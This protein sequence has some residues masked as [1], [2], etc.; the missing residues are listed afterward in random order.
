M[1]TR[2]YSVLIFFLGLSAAT[3]L[4]QSIIRFQIGSGIFFLDS[5]LWWFV[6]VNLTGFT[7]SVLTLKYYQYQKYSFALVAG[8][9]FTIIDNCHAIIIFARLEY[10]KLSSYNIPFLLLSST[11]GI[12][13]AVSLIFLGLKRKYW[14]A[15]TGIFMFAVGLLYLITS[16]RMIYFP[17]GILNTTIEKIGQWTAFASSFIPV[18]FILHFLG[19]RKKLRGSDTE[20]PMPKQMIG[21][22]GLGIVCFILTV[23]YG[24]W[25]FFESRSK[26][27]WEQYNFN[28]TKQ[29][30]K[31]FEFRTF[32][33]S[34]G[35]TLMYEL[36]R[37][38][39]Y[40][41]TKKYPLIVSLPYGAQTGTDTIKQIEGAVAAEL[42][43]TE[44][45]REKYPSFIFI[46][47]CPPGSGWGGIPNYPS[48][49]SLVYETI[50]SLDENFSIDTKRRYVIGLSRGGYGAW[51]FICTRPDMFA[52]AIPVAGGGNPTL[53][54][55]AVD[56]AVW[57]FHGKED[58][59]VPVEA[60]RDMIH[61]LQKAGGH[62][63]YTEFPDK[64]H[65]IWNDVSTTPGLLDWLFAQ[66]RN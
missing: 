38:L 1:N 37:R 34:N 55:N 20:M 52:A 47:H 41:S 40:D 2:L 15:I 30:A 13:Y 46:P 39:H 24:V 7:A 62:P 59:N 50:S 27:Y 26:M 65:N 3:S 18:L 25:I 16:V 29:L 32:T 44:H 42:L 14:L 19:E 6:M 23:I 28:K 57:A 56:V 21:L 53:A 10:Q 11:I 5:F 61:A 9:I 17:A 49:D 64:G 22:M 31:L 51:N 35:N 66:K 33:N 36:L 60:D 54:H 12:V 45:N 58:K 43:S 48:V 63:N 8:V 4:L